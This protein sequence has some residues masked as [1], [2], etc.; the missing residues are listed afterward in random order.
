MCPQNE[1]QTVFIVETPA[2]RC[3]TPFLSHAFEYVGWH[4]TTL[5]EPIGER[6]GAIIRCITDS[7]AVI[8]TGPADPDMAVVAGMASALGRRI[9]H[10]YAPGEL[11][12][13]NLAAVVDELVQVSED[14]PADLWGVLKHEEE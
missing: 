4:V 2:S 5:G 1:K 6:K 3:Y 12:S 8:I 13:A 9:V 10:L 7:D 11:T 14:A